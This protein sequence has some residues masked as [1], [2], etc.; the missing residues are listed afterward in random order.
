MPLLYNKFQRPLELNPL[1]RIIAFLPRRRL[2]ISSKTIA[3]TCAAVTRTG[4][5]L[6]R[7]GTDFGL[8]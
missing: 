4:G 5:E 1:C 7:K 3:A 2:S 6:G 8:V